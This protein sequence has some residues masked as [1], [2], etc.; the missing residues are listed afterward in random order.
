MTT[1]TRAGSGISIAAKDFARGAEERDEAFS[2]EQEAAVAL[3]EEIAARA[4]PALA[5]LSSAIVRG[6]AG[7]TRPRPY[8]NL[9]SA[10]ERSMHPARGILLATRGGLRSTRPLFDDYFD[11]RLVPSHGLYLLSDGRYAFFEGAGTISGDSYEWA[12]TLVPASAREVA[13]AKW[14][15]GLVASRLA[16]ELEAQREGI[17]SAA[18]DSRAR[19]SVMRA[20]ATLL[21]SS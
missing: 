21:G 20:I 1:L 3:L 2:E 12:S 8:E 13:S 14:R 9:E 11:A 16:D 6:E 10:R 4:A 17:A 15:P 19:A 7:T 5:K 18:K